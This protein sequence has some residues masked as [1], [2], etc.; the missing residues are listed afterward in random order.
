VE[1]LKAAQARMAAL[2]AGLKPLSGASG[3][4]T[5]AAQL[6]L[7]ER[8]RA[9]LDK[10]A[11]FAS[12]VA[13]LKASGVSESALQPL[14]AL[15]EKGAPTREALRNDLRRQRRTLAEDNAA[16]P[17]G[18]GE[19]ALNLA[20]RIVSVQRVDGGGAQTPAS[21]VE[22]MDASLA[23]GDLA[24]AETAWKALPEPARRAS[25]A[26]GKA[27]G[28]RVAADAALASLGQSAVRALQARQE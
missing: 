14:A 21:L 4:S 10:G 3:Q 22:K 20:G 11:P 12:D 15:A 25:A 13:A 6:L 23:A 9:A 5:A 18:W 8:I 2:E 16:Q 19:R 28:E 27:L 24:A 26:L 17:S 7:A 1:S